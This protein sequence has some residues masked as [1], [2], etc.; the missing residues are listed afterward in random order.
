M[1]VIATFTGWNLF[2]EKVRPF[3]VAGLLGASIWFGT[4]FKK[5]LI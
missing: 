5:W 2:D 1:I 3:I 4:K